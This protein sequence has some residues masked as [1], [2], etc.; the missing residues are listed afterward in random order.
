MW[1]VFCPINGNQ[2]TR[3]LVPEQSQCLCNKRETGRDVDEEK[4]GHDEV[5]G[6]QTDSYECSV[7]LDIA[8]VGQ[9]EVDRSHDEGYDSD[10]QGRESP[11][12]L[13]CSSRKLEIPTDAM[14]SAEDDAEQG[15]DNHAGPAIT[16]CVGGVE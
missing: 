15:K 4:D 7:S 11:E 10:G 13:F 3:R 2:R 8:T 6:H 12:K 9:K 1:H 14:E 5:Q 16:G